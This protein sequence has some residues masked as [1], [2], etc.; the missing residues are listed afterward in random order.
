MQFICLL[1]S[2]FIA[3][4][5]TSIASAVDVPET[6]L[7]KPELV[8]EK[9]VST[10][11][12]SEAAPGHGLAVN[13]IYPAKPR[14]KEGAP[15]VVVAPGGEGASG[16]EFSTHAA[17]AGFCEVRF[18]FP[19]GGK[20]GFASA[21]IYDYRGLFSQQ[22]L[23]DVLLFAGGKLKDTHGRTIDKL[24]PVPVVTKDVGLI[25][26]SNGGNI[27]VITLAKFAQ[28]LPFVGTLTFYES[29]M[30]SM[31]YPPMLGGSQD[32]MVN[33][34]YRQGSA[35]TG[36]CI[37]DYQ[38]LAYQE[39]GQRS[40]GAHRK[41]GQPEI[42]GIVFYDENG[43]K[44]WDEEL[45]FAF[46]Y[47]CDVGLEKQ[48]YPPHVT[49]ALRNIINGKWPKYVATLAESQAYFDERDGS[50]FFKELAKAMPNLFICVVG[51]RLDH[52][53]RQP[54]HPHIPL[55]YN[56]WLTHKIKFVRLNPDPN[57]VSAIAGMNAV[58]FT[59]NKP[60]TEIDAAE[61]DAHLEPEGYIPD[62]V[63][64]EAAIAE[65]SDRKKTGNLTP[66]LV[67]PLVAYSPKAKK[68]TSP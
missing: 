24:V 43:N 46:P 66:Y 30:G 21:G 45:E 9:S 2:L 47:C 6:S 41:V 56:A 27:A 63:F 60:G 61:L 38:K 31:F 40:P 14:Y 67:A 3:L 19:G 37:V 11:I 55:N 8:P 17:Q 28:Q 50:L 5:M 32:L 29:P 35:A 52:L 26:W 68:V 59:D 48:I 7:K 36:K 64:V 39:K 62:Y 10:F 57:Y 4:S 65:L 51:T 44:E 42:P 15:V 12:P 13:V 20:P 16:L 49:L 33:R 22:A 18:A 54:D 58:N 25:G 1:L 34:H 53:Q 23:R